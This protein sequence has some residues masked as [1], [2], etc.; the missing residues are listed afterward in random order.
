MKTTI[1]EKFVIACG[2]FAVVCF[3]LGIVKMIVL[4]H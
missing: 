2:I 4:H 1:D 3:V